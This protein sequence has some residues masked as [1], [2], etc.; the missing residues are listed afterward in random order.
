MKR[1]KLGDYVMWESQGKG[2]SKKKIGRIVSIIPPRV[3]PRELGIT[4]VPFWKKSQSM[5]HYAASPVRNDN[6]Y[7]VEV[8]DNMYAR[9]KLYWPKTSSLTCCNEEHQILYDLI[10]EKI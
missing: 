9:P 5:S 3:H 1:F 8:R 2:V 10:Q 7:L 4:K 6:S